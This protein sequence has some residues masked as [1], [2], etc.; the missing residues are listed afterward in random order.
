MTMEE[1]QQRFDAI[2]Q[3]IRD[4]E[5]DMERDAHMDFINSLKQY[6]NKF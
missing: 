1:I 5:Q 6:V 3:D 2:Q 4:L